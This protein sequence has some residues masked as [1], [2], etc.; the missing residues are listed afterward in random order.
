MIENS[1]LRVGGNSIMVMFGKLMTNIGKS[2]LTNGE[3]IIAK[4][5]TKI[6]TNPT[7]K[8]FNPFTL[9]ISFTVDTNQKYQIVM[10]GDYKEKYKESEDGIINLS[11]EEMFRII[12]IS[13]NGWYKK[14]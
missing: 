3:A 11:D 2:I 14:E 4:N 8:L 5:K 10:Q 1:T 6:V 9:V 12:N 13:V 7:A